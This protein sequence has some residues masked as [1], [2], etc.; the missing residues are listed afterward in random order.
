MSATNFSRRG[1]LKTTGAA[2]GGLV[3]GFSLAGCAESASP[4]SAEAGSLVPNA[5]LEITPGNIIRFFCPRDEM[6]QGVTTG[7][8]TLVAEELDVDPRRIEIELAGPHPDYVNPAFGLQ[9]TGG[10][11][12]ML[13]HFLQLRQMGAD[14]RRLLLDAAA[15]DLG[16]PVSSLS[17]EDGHVVSNGARHP[18]GSFAA[19][20]SAL[21]LPEESPLKPANEFKYIGKE[22]PRLDG[23]DKSTGVSVYG[24]DVEVPGMLR[25]VVRRSPVI[26]GALASLNK[27]AA[28][29]M[30]GVTR[31]VEIDAGVAVVA[32]RYWQAKKAAEKLEIDWAPAELSEVDTARIKSD[33]QR[34]MEQDQGDATAEKGDLAAGFEAAAVVVENDYWA[35]YLAHAPMEPMNAVAH[36]QGDHADV[37]CGTQGI[38]AAQKIVARLAN[39]DIDKV[40]AHSVY[41]GG[42]FGRRATLTHVVEATQISLATGKPIQ[43]LWSREDDLKSGVFR[44]ASLMRIKAGVDRDG[45][46]S[47]WQAKRVGGNV[48]P[49]MLKV[50]LPAALPTMISDGVIDWISGMAEGAMD[51]W[52]VDPTSIEGLYEDYDLPNREVRHVTMDHGLPLTVWRSVGHSFT[53]FAKETVIDELAQHSRLDAVEIRLRNTQNKPRLNQVIKVAGERMREMNPAPGHF[54]GFAAHHSFETDVAEV[55]EVSVENGKIRV[56]RVLCVV[57]CGVAVNPDIVRAQMEGAIMFGLTAAL[58]GQ[59]DLDHGEVTQSNFHD[60]PILRMNEAPDVEVIII[61]SDAHPTG[62]GEPGL[63]PI[64]PAVAN[65]VYAATGQRLRSL[66]LRLG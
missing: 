10:S 15:Q 55:A 20:A 14:V 37:W 3:I 19:T 60:Y 16:V 56:H 26:G 63:P 5:F 27:T 44:P 30:P 41:L 58:H 24:I 23:M 59:I 47:A 61:D 62:V 4:I 57:N 50:F 31:V 25:A 65:A 28:A 33:Y 8:T 42:G 29:S 40:R 38:G 32:E 1:F 49:G 7:L 48:A 18:Y 22:F 6:G 64:A 13:V 51:G 9:S 34:A 2:G 21:P 53:A 39:L 66:P 17:T 52:V 12:S 35:P 54:L 43:V 36:V 45:R 46:I 11:T